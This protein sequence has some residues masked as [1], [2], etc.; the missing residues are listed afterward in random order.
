MA[1]ACT[2]NAMRKAAVNKR[3]EDIA[4][5]ERLRLW[6]IH[7][8]QSQ[9]LAWQYGG[10]LGQTSQISVAAAAPGASAPRQAGVLHEVGVGVG[11][12]GVLFHTYKRPVGL[13]GPALRRVAQVGAHDLLDDLL[14]DGG[15][16]DRHQ[17]LD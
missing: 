15:V 14:M 3:R 13:H 6:T 4:F 5:A 11:R 10:S 16:L 8:P 17:G 1:L 9:Q 2:G 12:L 7:G